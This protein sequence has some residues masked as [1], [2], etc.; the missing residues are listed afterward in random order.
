M[1]LPPPVCETPG[2][3]VYWQ[4]DSPLSQ[5]ECR[6]E[7]QARLSLT[8][9]E[10]RGVD[11]V[12]RGLLR[13]RRRVEDL[14]LYRVLSFQVL[15]A[16]LLWE[17]GLTSYREYQGTNVHRPAWA[18][19]DPDG[20]MANALGFSVVTVTGDRKVMFHHRSR[21]MGER[22]GLWQRTAARHPQPPS[23]LEQAVLAELREEIGVVPTELT[24]PM[25]T[26]GLGVS[27]Q[28]SKPELSVLVHLNVT[29]AEVLQRPAID[30]WEYDRLA[31]A[32]WDPD[33][34]AE[35]AH[36]NRE[37]CVAQGLMTL[38]LGGAVDFGSEWMKATLEGFTA[39]GPSAPSGA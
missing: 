17:F 13:Q 31:P 25:I 37:V 4:G 19:R 8:A 32:R 30:R 6:F 12:W 20:K 7:P 24:G 15:G 22:E 2:C 29:A 34:V 33:S 27:N 16:R 9:A 11:A 28:T 18:L 39:T 23:T 3:T 21:L 35:W 38:I 10:R 36:R 5:A 14:P 1:R 26:C